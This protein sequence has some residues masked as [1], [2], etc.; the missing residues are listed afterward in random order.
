MDAAMHRI[1]R[2]RSYTGFAVFLLAALSLVAPSGYSL[3]ALMLVLASPMLLARRSSLTLGRQ[4]LAI[5]G[6]MLAY[7]AVGV[8]WGGMLVEG[9]REVDKPM[10]FALAVLALLVVIAYPPRLAW[11]WAGLALGAIGAGSWAAW[12]RVAEGIVRVA[13]HTHPIQFG[14]ISMLLGVMCLAGLGWAICQRPRLAW[15]SLLTLGALLGMLGSLFSGSRGGWVGVPFMLLVLYRAYLRQM[16][17]QW[18]LG[19]LAVVSISALAVMTIPQLGV[20]ARLLEA[21][22]DVALY[23]SGE[24]LATS[25]GTR[26]EMWKGAFMVIADR[27]LLGVG[28]QGYLSAMQALAEDGV[29]HP[30]AARYGH[31]HNEVLDAFAKRG[32]AGLAVLLALYLVPLRCFVAQLQAQDLTRRSLA[33]AGALLCVA[34][35]DFGL[36]QAFLAHNSGVMMFA[37]LLAV[38]WGSLSALQRSPS[39][40]SMREPL[41]EEEGEP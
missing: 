14:N 20:Q 36:S 25:V 13:G 21:F 41:A 31:P 8:I 30:A 12:Q 37:F 16:P 3:G 19:L 26:F 5:I 28:E 27:P 9:W 39:V 15:V 35:I 38:L 34:Y 24:N 23:A 2:Q 17:V 7:A 18:R 1:S 32:V 11:L 33:T 6:V 22:S 10:R 4:D 40:S 29:I